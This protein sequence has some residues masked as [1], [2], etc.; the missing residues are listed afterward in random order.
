M[1]R[2]MIVAG[3]FVLMVVGCATIMHGTSQEVGVSS[4]PSGASVLVDG[5]TFGTTPVVVTLKRNQNHFVRLEL[6]GYM[7]F[8][9]VLTRS[10][11]GWVW[12]NLAFGGV[13]GLVVD[14]VSGGIYKLTPDQVAAAL[15]KG[16]VSSGSE[17][18]MLYLGIVLEPEP[19]WE[20][21]GSLAVE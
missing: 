7:P 14:V 17:G 10:L 15:R 6:P 2:A 12:G 11:S 20:K 8:E 21:V 16:D 5:R 1:Y 3:M 13:I 4:S 9:I 18:G 19:E